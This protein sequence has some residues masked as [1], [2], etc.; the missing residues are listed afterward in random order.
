[1]ATTTTTSTSTGGI[2]S[3]FPA[4][5][6]ETD[7]GS[8]CSRPNS[9]SNSIVAIFPPHRSIGDYE[10]DEI[11]IA[12]NPSISSYFPAYFSDTSASSVSNETRLDEL[13]VIIGIEKLSI[14]EIQ[15]LEWNLLDKK[16]EKWVQTMKIILSGHCDQIF[17]G[18]T[19]DE[20]KEICFN[21]TVKGCVMQLLNFGKAVAIGRRSPEKLF[22]ML[23]MY[24]VMAKALARLEVLITDDVVINEA[25]DVLSE[26]GE[27]ACGTLAE[28]ENA[29]QSETSSKPMQSGEIHHLTRYV[30]NYVN[31]IVDNVYY[32]GTLNFLLEI[33]EDDDQ[34]EPLRN[35][36]SDS[37]KLTPVAGRLLV[38]ITSL[39]SNLEEKSKLYEDGALQY[40]FLMN[41]ILYVVQKV[42]GS[43]LGGLV[44][45]NWVRK[46]HG[47]IRQ[48]A[49][50]Y[51][52]ASWTK[53]LHCLK[54]EG[55]GGSSRNAS[56]VALK[57]RFKNFNAC[58]EKIYTVQTAWKVPDAQL[59]EELRISISE[60]VIPAYRSFMGR[61][62]N[63]VESGRHAGKYIKYTADDL[64]NYL[65]DLW[66][67]SPRVLHHMRRR[68]TQ[69]KGGLL[70]QV[71]AWL[72]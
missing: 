45:D 5:K 50:S 66:E 67:G 27:A 47:Q 53:V 8:L 35:D 69:D 39:H 33:R 54:V 52:R 63:Q 42:E 32:S 6:S 37:S 15:K 16:A 26:L 43:D 23:D 61:F 4:T 22:R 17:C 44:G 9:N 7:S 59:R 3:L 21:E 68:S 71:R 19:T 29:V 14:S 10:N 11:I 51:L 36:D 55:I 34:L 64:E 58:F 62:G 20:T 49:I 1:M 30:M 56:R 57:E 48:Y 28:F 25:R 60:K 41:N 13:L 46:R 72:S 12:Q 31:L 38:L 2:S 24:D 65:L 18:T 70:Y 40:I